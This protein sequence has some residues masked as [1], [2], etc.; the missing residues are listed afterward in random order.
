MNRSTRVLNLKPSPTLAVGARANELRAQG[1][2]ILNLSLGEPDFPTPEPIRLAGQKAIEQGKTKYTPVAGIPE[3]REAIAAFYHRHKGL[4][5]NASNIVV[6]T[7]AKQSL[8]NAIMS[9]VNEGDEVIIPT[10]YWVSYTTQVEL[11]GG[12]PVLVHSKMEDN[13]QL[14]LEA[15]EASFSSKTKMLL[16]NSPNNPTGAVYTRESMVAVAELLKK[17]PDVWLLCDD[18]YDQLVYGDK[19]PVN[20]LDVEPSLR[21]RTILVNGFSKAYAMTGW[22]IGYIV[23]PEPIVKASIALQGAVTSGTNAPTQYAALQALDESLNSTIQDMR[24]TFAERLEFMKE[25]FGKLPRTSYS[26]PSG[27]FYMM[28]DFTRWLGTQTPSGKQLANTVEMATYFLEEGHVAGVPGEAFGAP[29]TI[30][31]AYSTSKETIQKAAQ[32]IQD[33]LEQLSE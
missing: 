30:R 18:I 10:P 31:F 15:L 33:A 3:L 9:V 8:Y 11:A 4:N 24:Q 2:E 21:E 19:K 20:P 16:L 23:A 26:S 22:R 1:H 29:G 14:D 17:H 5:C 25:T 28:I 6:S 7:G 13:Y 32:A 12:T 27:A